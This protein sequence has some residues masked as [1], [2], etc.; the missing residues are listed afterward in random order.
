MA[1]LT[2]IIIILL[3]PKVQEIIYWIKLVDIRVRVTEFDV[4]YDVSLSFPSSPNEYVTSCLHSGT[5]LT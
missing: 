5:T 2:V 1:V 3:L 4:D